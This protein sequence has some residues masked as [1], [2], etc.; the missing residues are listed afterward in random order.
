MQTNYKTSDSHLFG[1]ESFDMVIT[2]LPENLKW[3]ISIVACTFKKVRISNSQYNNASKGVKFLM[4][5]N[6][7]FV[8]PEMSWYIERRLLHSGL[9]GLSNSRLQPRKS[10]CST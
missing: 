6:T 4:H 2:K 5:L 9:S 10:T 8:L 7:S 3:C 1:F